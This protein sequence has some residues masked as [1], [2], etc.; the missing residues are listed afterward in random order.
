MERDL[1][2]QET[3]EEA[4]AFHSIYFEVL[5]EHGW[6]G[7]AI[8][9]AVFAVFFLDMRRIRRQVRGRPDLEWLGDLASALSHCMLIFMA[10]GAF[11]G[12]AFQPLQYYLFALAVSASAALHRAAAAPAPAPAESRVASAM[13]GGWRQRAGRRPCP[14]T[15]ASAPLR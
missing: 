9:L 7:L 13:L 3:V 2:G 11:I 1:N 4:R 5:G 14:A 8:F 12:V 6:I 10:G 15:G